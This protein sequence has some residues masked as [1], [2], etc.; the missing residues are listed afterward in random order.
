MPAVAV[1]SLM[2]FW[3]LLMSGVML[4]I[5]VKSLMLFWLLLWTVV[6]CWLLLRIV[7]CHVDFCWGVWCH[8]GYC[9]KENLVQCCLLW[10]VRCLLTSDVNSLMPCC[11]FGFLLVPNIGNMYICIHICRVSKMT[12]NDNACYAFDDI[13]RLIIPFISLQFQDWSI[14]TCKLQYLSLIHI[15]EPTRR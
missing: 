4:A 2:S 5:A 12:H 14:H 1:S 7:W 13:Y 15:S 3:L 8:A 9:C 11:A 6:S 10:T